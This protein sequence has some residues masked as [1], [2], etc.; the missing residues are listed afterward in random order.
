MQSAD[1][2]FHTKLSTQPINQPSNL[3][4]QTSA[5]DRPSN[6]SQRRLAAA[7]TGASGG[8][9]AAALGLLVSGIVAASTHVLPDVE[10][11]AA[12]VTGSAA[13]ADAGLVGAAAAASLALAWP[14]LAPFVEVWRFSQ[15]SGEEVEEVVAIKEPLQVREKE[16]ERAG[17]RCSQW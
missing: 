3:S 10:A 9:L 17:W 1:C 14:V 2:K 6:V 5:G 4:I 12:V 7:I 8:R 13:A 15:L 11:A 16:R